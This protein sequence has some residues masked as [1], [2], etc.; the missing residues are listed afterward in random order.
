[1]VFLDFS[2]AFNSI[3]HSLL[4]HKLKSYGFSGN[5]HKWFSS[6]LHS[7][8]QR[9]VLAMAWNLIGYLSQPESPRVPFLVLLCPFYILM[10]LVLLYL[11]EHRSLYK[12][13]T[14]RFFDRFGLLPEDCRILQS[15]LLHLE[16]WS[17]I[18]KLNFNTDK[19]KMMSFSRNI[20]FI[21]LHVQST[22]RRPR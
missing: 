20:K 19:C 11:P 3:S 21:S 12:P 6:Y 14:R 22:C 1:M 16:R 13:T 7:R 2:K 10:I 8:F 5:I 15:D 9:V 17:E 18:W 4:L